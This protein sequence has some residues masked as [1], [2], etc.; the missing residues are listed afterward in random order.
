M[1]SSDQPEV[2]VERHFWESD[3]CATAAVIARCLADGR[4]GLPPIAAEHI[5]TWIISDATGQGADPSDYNLVLASLERQLAALAARHP[6]GPVFLEV[7]GGTPAMTTGLLIAGTEIFGARAELLSIHPRHERP[8]T[9]NT[10]QRLL[11][12]PL[13]ATLRSNAATYAYDA[14]LRT[15]REHRATIADRLAPDA[16]ATIEPLLAYAHCRYS[17]DFS[18]ARTALAAVPP[19]NPWVVDLAPLAAAVV[20]PDRRALLA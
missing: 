14:A 6:S 19:T 7:T 11:A 20:A 13:R 2:Q 10:G 4:H 3:T 5:S 16:M 17:F 12:A 18:G 15:L 9:L 1:R 8:A